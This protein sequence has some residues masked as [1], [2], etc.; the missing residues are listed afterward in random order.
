MKVDEF[1]KII[2]AEKEHTPSDVRILCSIIE[3]QRDALLCIELDETGQHK[4]IAR[5]ELDREV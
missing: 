1:V 5:A 2:R 4:E 3:R